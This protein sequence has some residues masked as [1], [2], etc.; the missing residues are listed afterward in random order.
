MARKPYSSLALHFLIN[1]PAMLNVQYARARGSVR[2]PRDMETD[3]ALSLYKRAH[4][5]WPIVNVVRSAVVLMRAFPS[6]PCR[7]VQRSCPCP[8]WQRPVLARWRARAESQPKDYSLARKRV[9]DIN[10]HLTLRMPVR[11][12]KARFC[13]H[14]EGRERVELP[15]RYPERRRMTVSTEALNEMRRVDTIECRRRGVDVDVAPSR[16]NALATE[17]EIVEVPTEERYPAGAPQFIDRVL[18]RPC[19]VV[20]L[21]CQD[22]QLRIRRRVEE[23]AEVL[24][25]SLGEED[26]DSEAVHFCDWEPASG[27]VT[28][29]ELDRWQVDLSERAC[30]PFALVPDSVRRLLSARLSAKGHT[31]T[32]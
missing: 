29:D 22:L 17:G 32:G 8:V 13:V 23:Q 25:V 14:A 11:A 6:W 5:P 26:G 16:P 9:T 31:L 4:A 28:A 18:K 24:F 7:F 1:I 15:A 2:T 19:D 20:R 21:P 12:R 27:H 10:Q 30:P 3:L